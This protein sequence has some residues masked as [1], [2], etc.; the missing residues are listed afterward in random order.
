MQKISLVVI[1]KNEEKNI[2]RCLS[3]VT[4]ASEKIVVDSHSTDATQKIAEANGAKVVL[5]EFKGYR[6]QKEF[7]CSQASN[8]WILILDADEALSPQLSDE[9]QFL[10]KQDLKADAFDLPRRTFHLGKW[11]RY[12]GWHPDYQ[13]RLFNKNVVSWASQELHENLIAKNVVRLQHP[14]LHWGFVDLKHQIE[15]NNRYSTMGA[16]ELKRQGKRFS[17]IKLISKP[18]GK[19]LECYFFKLGI[20]DGLPGFVIAV[21]AAYSMFLKWAKLWELNAASSDSKRDSL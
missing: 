18:W 14:I 10:L 7:A 12:G 1:T 5:K 16:L 4:F 15:T 21:G 13:R 17:L 8:H 6:E 11:I 3:S 2:A 20:L 9:L 19:F